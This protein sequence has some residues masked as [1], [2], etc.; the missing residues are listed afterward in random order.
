MILYKRHQVGEIYGKD[1]H[2]ETCTGREI[3]P[4]TLGFVLVEITTPY[5]ELFVIPV[6][7]TERNGYFVQFLPESSGSIIN[8]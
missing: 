2:P 1:I 5:G 8:D 3:F 6:F 4:V 7:R